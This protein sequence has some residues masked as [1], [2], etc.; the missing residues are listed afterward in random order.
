M[1]T[2]FRCFISC[3]VCYLH[4]V[5]EKTYNFWFPKLANIAKEMS[6]QRLHKKY[7]F[8]E[9]ANKEIF[10]IGIYCLNRVHLLD[11]QT[12]PVG[13]DNCQ[14]YK[15]KLRTAFTQAL[16][17]IF[18]IL[19]MCILLRLFTS[20]KKNLFFVHNKTVH[21][22]NSLVLTILFGRINLREYSIYNPTLN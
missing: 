19:Y 10:T 11:L 22:R 3:F 2:I 17:T 7:F 1:L 9:V 13:L 20:L 16:T 6:L 8:N 4:N 5:K 15:Y 14:F 18:Y 21:S 12:R